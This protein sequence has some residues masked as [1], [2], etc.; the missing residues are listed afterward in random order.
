[1]DVVFKSEEL[2]RLCS[3]EKRGVK[4]L[5]D[6]C[7]RRLRSRLA[8]LRAARRLGDVVAGRPHPLTGDRAGQ[9]A[10]AL[11]DGRRLVLEPAGPVIPKTPEGAIDWRN[12][13]AVC[14]AYVGN[15]HD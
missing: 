12:V 14:V 6:S 5:G 8:D 11:S 7:A 1:M 15:Y 3:E 9:F 2:Q 4:R 10:V 13:E